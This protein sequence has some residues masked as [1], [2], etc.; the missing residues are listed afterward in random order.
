MKPVRLV[1]MILLVSFYGCRSAKVNGTSATAMPARNIIKKHYENSFDKETI[2]ARLR[3]K[4]T[5]KSDLPN[6]TATMRVK[7]D[8]VIW[9]SLSKL[10]FPLAKALIT[11]TKVSYYEKINQTYFEGD[12]SML[13]N[14]LGTELDYEKVQNLLLG[15]AILNLKKDTYTASLSDNLYLLSPKEQPE[16]FALLFVINPANFKIKKQEVLELESH[17]RLSIEYDNYRLVDGQEFPMYMV[18]TAANDKDKSTIEV[19]YK[20]VTFDEP[21]SFPFSIPEGYKQVTLK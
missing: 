6:I 21:V 20:T 15:Q 19:E 3:V 17:N 16:L 4:Y 7:K 8:E 10:G 11:P 14:W 12:F 2:N 18:I 9:I 5:G 1:I 13:S